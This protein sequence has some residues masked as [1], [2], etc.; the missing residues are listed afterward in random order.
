MNILKLIVALLLLPSCESDDLENLTHVVTKEVKINKVIDLSSIVNETSGLINFNGKLITHNDSGGKPHLYEID[1]KTG[2]ITRT[3]EISNATNIDMEAIAQDE[4][5]IYLCDIGNNS[6][7]RK[8][9]TIY[10]ISKSD[11]L[12]SDNITAEKIT[13]SY[14]EQVDFSRTNKT[15]NFDAE[16]VVGIGN[17]LFLFTKNWGNLKTVVYKIPKDKGNYELVEIDSYDIDG[18]ITGADYN[19]NTKTLVLTGYQNFKPFV[20]KLTNFSQ[21]NPLDGEIEKT[22]IN[23]FGSPQIEGI[24]ANSDGSYFISAEKSGGFLASLYQLK[25]D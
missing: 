8:D 12:A 11:Y 7:K 20:V 6:N 21:N 16:A 19:E 25:F 4:S 1:V 22:L 14:K 18:L 9:Q 10:K 23:I 5:Y 2:N 13:I 24:S 17:D 3:V 15:T